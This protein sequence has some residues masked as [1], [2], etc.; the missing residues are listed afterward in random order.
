MSGYDPIYATFDSRLQRQ[1]RREAYGEDIGQHSWVSADELRVDIGRLEL[2]AASRLLDAGCG[3]G[4]P[5]VWT[6][7]ETGCRGVG[8]DRSPAALASARTR[9]EEAGQS[10]RVEL[11][12]HDL[13][14]P[15]PFPDRSFAAVM[16]LD[17]VVHVGDRAAF[18]R[19]IARVLEPGGRFLLTDGSVQSGPI[20]EDERAARSANAPTT[21][22]PPAANEQL[23]GAAGFRI[24]TRED[25]TAAARRAADARRRARAAHRADLVALEGETSV[26]RQERLLDAIVAL[27]D[28]GALQRV[29]YLAVRPG[30]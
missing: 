22:V 6:V 10:D 29:A 17:V 24:L 30:G 2:R 4:G 21:L 18:F 12:E 23:L 16:A 14:Q 5:L 26:L 15:L 8:I 9:A 27:T 20:T 11:H 25:R 28:R 1:I 3:P 7:R 13:D 19:E